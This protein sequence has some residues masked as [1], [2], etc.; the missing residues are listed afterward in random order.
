M[1]PN[2][3]LETWNLKLETWLTATKSK[4]FSAGLRPA[5]LLPRSSSNGHSLRRRS[6]RRVGL[7]LRR[8]NPFSRGLASRPTSSR[9][10][11][12]RRWPRL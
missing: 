6:R 5:A 12:R 4:S 9:L 10:A 2:L 8:S 11:A 3:K 7:H 1:Q